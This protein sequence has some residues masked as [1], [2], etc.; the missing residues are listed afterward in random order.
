ML[1]KEHVLIQILNIN[2]NN[3]EMLFSKRLALPK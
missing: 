1:T 3:Y 2:V